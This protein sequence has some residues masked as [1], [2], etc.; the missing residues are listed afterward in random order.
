M[1]MNMPTLQFKRQKAFRLF[2]LLVVI[3]VIG[4]LAGLLFPI[5]QAALKAARRFVNWAISIL[6]NME[7]SNLN[8]SFDNRISIELSV[9]ERLRTARVSS[10]LCPFDP[11]TAVEF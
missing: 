9:N 4:V 7:Q 11:R 2:E 6:P 3:S 1:I 10:Y 5:V 8:S